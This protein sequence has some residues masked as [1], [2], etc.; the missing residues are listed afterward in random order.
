VSTLAAAFAAGAAVVALES[1]DA[2]GQLFPSSPEKSLILTSIR[3]FAAATL[4]AVRLSPRSVCVRCRTDA[5]QFTAYAETI[6]ANS[7]QKN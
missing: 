6:N 2:A 5:A 7:G 1:R 4:V 3:V